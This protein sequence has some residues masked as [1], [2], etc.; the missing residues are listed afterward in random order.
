[1]NVKNYLT[2][3]ISTLEEQREKNLI[4]AWCIYGR[5]STNF[6]HS[7]LENKQ[8]PCLG[9]VDVLIV[10]PGSG[11]TPDSLFWRLRKLEMELLALGPIPLDV[12]VVDRGSWEVGLTFPYSYGSWISVWESA[13]WFPCYLK[14]GKYEKKLAV[15]QMGSLRLMHTRKWVVYYGTRR[16][17]N[18]YNLQDAITSGIRALAD[19]TE[20]LYPETG[21]LSEEERV[22][23]GGELFGIEDSV[24]LLLDIKK[25]RYKPPVDGKEA[26]DLLFTAKYVAEVATQYVL[27]LQNAISDPRSNS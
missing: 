11:I 5:S 18:E 23:A 27:E 26:I 6:L 20:F 24:R 17:C 16:N 14:P 2:K 22:L 21:K 10:T 9:D 7:A 19:M 13:V 1:M 15:L 4:D 3:L 25:R 8:P 12:S